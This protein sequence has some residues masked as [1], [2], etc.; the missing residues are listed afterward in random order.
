MESNRVALVQI[1]SGDLRRER[2]ELGP[3]IDM[4]L[5]RV[6]DRGYFILGTEVA[7]FEREFAAYCGVREA[8]AVASGTDAIMI[9]IAALELEAGD[10]V[11]TTTLTSMATVT[12]IIRAGAKPVL[13]DIDSD[14][15]N[16]DIAGV[17]AS[18]SHRT[19]AIVPVHLYG[20]AADM[21]PLLELATSRHVAIIEDACQA[22]GATVGARKV[23]AIG[24]AGCFSFYPS[25]NLGAYGDGGMIT[26][27]DSGF[28]G[29]CR[30]LR[31][32]GWR[33]RD[34][35]EVLG[36]NSR[37]DEM[38]AAVLRTKLPHLDRWNR[39]RR[40]IA[41]RYRKHLADRKE[42]KVPADAPGHVFHLFVVR[43]A[44]RDRVR[45]GLTKQGIATGVH[46]PLP[47]HRQ[48]ALKWLIH[49]H[50]FPQADLVSS[51]ILSLPMFPQLTDSEVDRVCEALVDA[52]TQ[53][54]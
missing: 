51:E 29:R 54:A 30:L 32:Y 18:L 2:A 31:Q 49:K 34:R 3:D 21:N 46:Y 36:F 6:L 8:V 17:A 26:T 9:S 33:E 10:E 1:P 5:D 14:T 45:E 25:K 23:G 11:I 7:A 27:D 50:G 47:M 38:Q 43:V 20:R 53:H 37:L 13:V 52:I 42:V 19:R 16:L 4:A 22:H 48:P 41:E 39:R 24:L 28:A 40:T 12:A 15:F 35:S 44:D